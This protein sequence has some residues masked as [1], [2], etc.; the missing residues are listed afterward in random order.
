MIRDL[1]ASRSTVTCSVFILGP[2]AH[3]TVFDCFPFQGMV[4]TR[5]CC[6][7]NGS[8]SSRMREHGVTAADFVTSAESSDWSA[9]AWG[10][11]L[12]IKLDI[13]IRIIAISEE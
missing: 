4:V 3:P 7:S 9:D 6:D 5:P 1:S 8:G 2:I 13:T 10:G 12:S 11:W